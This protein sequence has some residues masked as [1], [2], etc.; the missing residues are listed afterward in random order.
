MVLPQVPLMVSILFITYVIWVDWSAGDRK[1]LQSPGIDR[2][3]APDLSP[4]A[5]FH[6][7]D[8]AAR[9]REL[10]RVGVC[11]GRVRNDQQCG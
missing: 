2:D 6:G 8:G 10:H 5:L 1:H 7:V 3:L 4:V 11:G 9:E